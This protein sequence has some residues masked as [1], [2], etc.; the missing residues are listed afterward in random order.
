M[1]SIYKTGIESDKVTK[2]KSQISYVLAGPKISASE[3]KN[4]FRSTYFNFLPTEKI[5]S[6]F[7]YASMNNALRGAFITHRQKLGQT[8][9][10]AVRLPLESHLLRAL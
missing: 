4:V 3:K 2:R 7:N 10:S 5:D 8:I 9:E 1:T 6:I